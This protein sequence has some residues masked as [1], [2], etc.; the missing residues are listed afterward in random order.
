MLSRTSHLILSAACWLTLTVSSS[1]ADLPFVHPLFSEHAVLQRGMACPVWGWTQP[2]AKVRVTFQGKSV[3]ATAAADG[4]WL[5]NLPP[6]VTGG[7]WV[8]DIEGPQRVAIKDV[9]VGDVWICSGQSNMEWTVANSNDAEKEIK[10]AAYPR[11]RLFT[12]PKR[13]SGDP[14][15]TV[16]AQWQNC[17]PETIP[18]FTAVGYFF[19]QE[20]FKQLDYPI[21]LIHSSWGGTIAEAW[22][23]AEAL[24]T[25]EDFK[26]AVD[27]TRQQFEAAKSGNDFNKQMADWWA[28]NDLGMKDGANWAAADASEEGWQK[29]ALPTLWESAGL[30]DFDGLVWFRRSFEVPAE[31]A[32]KTAKL[33]LGTIDDRDD[34]YLN[35]ER[36]G[37]LEVFNAPRS[38]DIAA[39]KLK[40]GRNVVAIRVFDTGG[41]GGLTGPAEAMKL[42]IPKQEGVENDVTIPLNGEWLYK[43]SSPL[44]SMTPVPQKLGT[45]PNVVMVLYNGMIAPLVPYGIKGAI[46]YQG[47]SNAGRAAQYRTLLPTLINDWKTRFAAP[48]FSF[49]VVQLANFMEQQKDPVQSGWAELREAQALTAKN[50]PQVGLAVITDIGDAADIH[51]RNKQDVGKRLALQALAISYGRSGIVPAGPEFT[52]MTV[53]DGKATL[54]F[55]HVGAGLKAKGNELKGFAIAGADKKFVFAKAEIAG[56]TVVVSS[57]DVPMPTAVRYNWANNPIG[58]LFNAE[59]LPAAPFRTDVE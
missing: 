8:L 53:A 24:Q 32:G 46:W 10:A 21:G 17:T 11:I 51:P 42:T 44:A 26:A 41:G 35:G 23:S 13:I 45:N 54:K 27:T 50:D 34:T 18:N 6:L 25:M 12:V 58:N 29:M 38:F 57:P 56:Q 22:T 19:G 36:A 48:D 7:P 33:E 2:G 3:E 9:L 20:L 30:A 1:A 28:A 49:H 16:D 15:Q 37:G 52:E 31:L 4:K 43:A 55:N 59:G 39:G 14:Q 40:A 5:A 47:E